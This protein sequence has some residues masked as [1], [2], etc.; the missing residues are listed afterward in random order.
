VTDEAQPNEGRPQV[1]RTVEESQKL[2]FLRRG[3]GLLRV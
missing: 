2:P 3:E 1:D